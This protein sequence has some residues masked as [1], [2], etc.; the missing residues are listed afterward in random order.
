MYACL[1]LYLFVYLLVCTYISLHFF[2]PKFVCLSACLYLSACLRVC[3]SICLTVIICLSAPVNLLYLL[4]C[5]LIY[6]VQSSTFHNCKVSIK[7]TSFSVQ[8]NFFI[9]YRRSCF[10]MNSSSVICCPCFA[11]IF[12][13]TV[14]R[15]A[16]LAFLF[17]LSVYLIICFKSRTMLS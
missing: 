14:F 10:C 11:I 13:D 2:V 1:Y 8:L 6:F 12:K 5:M 16:K 7:Q 9:L 4:V 3:S 17:R 15:M